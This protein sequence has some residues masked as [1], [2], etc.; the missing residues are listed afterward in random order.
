MRDIS[1]LRFLVVEDHGFQRW[2]LG[3]MLQ[4]LGARHVFSAPDG[5]AALDFVKSADEPVDIVVSDLDM[6]GM[7]GMEFIRHLT[8]ECRDASLIIVSSLERSLIASVE[9][10]ARAYGANLIGAVEKPAT[11]RKMEAVIRLHAARADAIAS[12]AGPEFALEEILA[13]LGRGEFEPFFQPKVEVRSGIVRGAEA[14]ARWRHPRHGL[15]PPKAFMTVLEAAGK[16]DELTIAM[17]AD[18]ARACRRW[19][20]TGIEASVSVNVSITC[21]ADLTLAERMAAIVEAQGVSPANVVFEVTESAA[22]TDVGPVLENLTRLR[23]MGFG[24]SIDDVGT[25][26]S[27]MQRLSRV[28]FTELKIDRSFVKAAPLTAA[29]RVVLESSLEMA[30]RL[31]IVAVAEGVETQDEWRL[32]ND[33]QCP[34]AQGNLIAPPLEAHDFLLWVRRQVTR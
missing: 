22:A 11:A 8:R 23:M 5:Q 6:P 30:R 21:L 31:G 14:L 10:M 16:V 25:G 2:A 15:V 26:Y 33:L 24:L 13:G 12:V 7:D 19:R 17:V 27:S 3:N 9:G 4:G 20:E 29:N 34:L 1:E 32:L 28:P 18:G